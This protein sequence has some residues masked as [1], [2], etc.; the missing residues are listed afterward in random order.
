[1]KYNHRLLFILLVFPGVIV[2]TSCTS[3]VLKYGSN[4]VEE[5]KID[6]DV[7]T[8]TEELVINTRGSSRCKEVSPKPGCIA[9]RHNNS[10]QV[11]FQ[12]KKS[13]DWYL[14]EFKI[15]LGNTKASQ[16]CNLEEWQ[17][18]QF[19]A[20]DRNG[21]VALY[22]NISGIVNLTSLPNTDKEFYLVN[23]NVTKQD[24]FYTIEA[25]PK[26]NPGDDKSKCVYTDPPIQNGGRN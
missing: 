13:K 16:V 21:T 5:S 2:L 11:R 23:L 14:T 18:N 1:M 22:P 19:F 17:R 20:T 26:K 12:L 6:L 24:Y 3:G 4:R 10:G 15:C 25:C 9:V 8:M 7:N